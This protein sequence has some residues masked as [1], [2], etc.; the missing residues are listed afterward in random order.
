M[1]KVDCSC[2]GGTT[3]DSL[4]WAKEFKCDLMSPPSNLAEAVNANYARR[5]SCNISLV[6]AA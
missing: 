5:G 2:T 1:G 6:R 3:I 4:H